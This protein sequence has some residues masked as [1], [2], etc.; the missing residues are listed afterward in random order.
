MLIFK[1]NRILIENESEVDII[2]NNR[3]LI[4]DD[5]ESIHQDLK[6]I[7]NGTNSASKNEY[8]ILKKE[9]FG[10]DSFEDKEYSAN[11]KQFYGHYE[12]LIDSAYQG[13]EALAMVEKAEKENQQYALIFMDVRM[14]PGLD[15]IETISKIWQ[16]YP[17][18]EM[19]ICSAYS[20]YPWE[21]IVSRLGSSDKLLFLEKPFAYVEV[22]Q[23]T[24]ALIKKWNLGK[25]AKEYVSDL[26]A[27]ISKRTRQLE[28]LL[29]NLKMSIIVTEIDGKIIFTNP[30]AKDFFS[31]NELTSKN[32][33]EI[34]GTFPEVQAGL[35]KTYI[36]MGANLIHPDKGSLPASYYEE[37]GA[38]IY[39]FTLINLEG[40]EVIEP[41]PSILLII[42]DVTDWHL[43]VNTDGLTGLWNHRYFKELLEKEIKKSKR[44]KIPLSLI[45]IDVDHFKQFNDTYG[46][47]TGDIVL[48]TIAETLQKVARET[49][50]V[51]RYGGEEFAIVLPMTAED[52]ANIFAERLR[53][54][55]SELQFNDIYQRPLQNV[56]LS[57]GVATF[58]KG[59]LSSFIENADKAL[60]NCKRNGRNCVTSYSDL[61]SN[62]PL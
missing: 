7:L 19:V 42:E 24:L 1:N 62:G 46:H 23:M 52:G 10:D 57:L 18:I 8:N 13:N 53:K 22:Q 41:N 40:E 59:N 17:D 20:D 47:Q 32:L 37:S 38:L 30:N 54:E 5:N 39:K 43:R 27:K 58:I 55:I 28:N 11:A 45:M 3:I 36:E 44:Y 4:V 26:E 35:K 51:A 48:K 49:D 33:L 61:V 14:P 50:M 9:L 31:E 25:R 34:M 15:G 2:E 21:K 6:K 60:Y 56:T 29:N 12:Y 16:K